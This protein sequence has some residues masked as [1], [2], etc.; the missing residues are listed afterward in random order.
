MAGSVGVAVAVFVAVLVGGT[1][2]LVGVAV[3]VSV[4][5][6]GVLV[7]VFV[8]VLD[9]TVVGVAVGTFVGVLVG[10]SVGLSMLDVYVQSTVPP[11]SRV[12]DAVAPLGEALVPVPVAA[13]VRLRS[14]QPSGT[15]DSLTLYEPGTTL[16]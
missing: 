7:A 11:L 1:G 4:G 15:V 14:V 3:A 16:V 12:R 6:T 13:Q 10:I 5:G 9:G 2:V 8:G